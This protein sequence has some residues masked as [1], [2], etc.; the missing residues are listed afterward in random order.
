MK[1]LS[2]GKGPMRIVSLQVSLP[3]VSI[4][5]KRQSYLM[6]HGRLVVALSIGTLYIVLMVRWDGYR[7][8]Y[9][10]FSGLVS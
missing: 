10:V 4:Y 5:Q 9:A 3:L 8:G 2:Q 6:L 1:A 7:F